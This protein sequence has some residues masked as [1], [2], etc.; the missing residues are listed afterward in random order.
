[1]ASRFEKDIQ[2]ILGA[3]RRV[4]DNPTSVPPNLVAM[5]DQFRAMIRD[6]P[7]LCVSVLI[8]KGFTKRKAKSFLS[9]ILE[10]G[11]DGK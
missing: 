2:L 10:D 8:E 4:V 6:A 11:K 9:R 3:A 5:M 1:V 7:D